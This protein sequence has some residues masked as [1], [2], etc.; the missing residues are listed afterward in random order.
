MKIV[1][2]SAFL[3][4]MALPS[5]VSAAP[6][7]APLFAVTGERAGELLAID[8]STAPPLT[9]EA[10]IVKDS[11]TVSNS[12]SSPGEVTTLSGQFEVQD[13]DLPRGTVMLY[14]R[15]S[16]A[17]GV[18]A[19]PVIAAPGECWSSATGHTICRH[20]FSVDLT[21]RPFARE[22]AGGGAMLSSQLVA[23]IRTS[24]HDPLVDSEVDLANV[25]FSMGPAINW[26]PAGPVGQTTV[27]G[28]INY[29]RNVITAGPANPPHPQLGHAGSSFEPAPLVDTRV[30]VRDGCGGIHRGLTHD[31][32]SFELIFASA[33]PELPAE[34]VAV[35]E[36]T[37]GFIRVDVRDTK[38]DLHE[39]PVASFTPGAAKIH[40]FEDH[41][42]PILPG[43]TFDILQQLVALQRWTKQLL[44]DVH[45]Q[46]MPWAHAVYERDWCPAGLG[47][48]RYL[49][50]TDQIEICS[51]DGV[52]DPNINRDEFDQFTILHEGFHWFHDQFLVQGLGDS[53][54]HGVTR[55][56]TEGFATMMAGLMLGSPWRFERLAG[57]DVESPCGQHQFAVESLDFN[58]HMTWDK[59][60]GDWSDP[61]LPVDL[62][63]ATPPS[64]SGGWSWRILWDVADPEEPTVEEPW[65]E[66]TR[67][68]NGPP[69]HEVP[70]DF[71]TFGGLELFADVL[72]GYLHSGATPNPALPP[73]DARGFEDLD[74]VEVI[75]GVLCR[76]GDV[77]ID[78]VKM[79]LEVVMDLRQI[80]LTQTPAFCG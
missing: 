5:I 44:G 40:T 28:R 64:S 19:V 21:M 11:L 7:N 60:R 70:E 79:L 52:D 57:G 24:I 63:G 10:V 77:W 65:T 67:G 6:R 50:D 26:V 20:D 14:L 30:E 23:G 17:A 25:Q 15:E 3:A 53:Y 73:L 75:D 61:W 66:F 29:R 43:A 46:T 42:I 35:S 51:A 39:Y 76:S 16:A 54:Y 34:V 8:V 72:V 4:A 38:G 69:A 58:G 9:P 59:Q 31:D 37:R 27:R 12:T 80:D 68:L 45:F 62:W 47:T 48:S 78:D 71:D 56:F 32:G 18:I 55:E 41:L 1:T 36:S 2:T 33:C 13:S 74:V 22:L 49:P